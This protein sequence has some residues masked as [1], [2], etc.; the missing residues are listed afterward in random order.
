VSEFDDLVREH[1][2]SLSDDELRRLGADV[3]VDISFGEGEAAHPEPSP[4]PG[5]PGE[6]ERQGVEGVSLPR[7]VS[8]RSLV[9][10]P[11]DLDAGDFEPSLSGMLYKGFRI[12]PE[13]EWPAEAHRY[14]EEGVAG[15]ANQKRR[16]YVESATGDI[17][18]VPWEGS[19]VVWPW[20]SGWDQDMYRPEVT[21][22]L[23]EDKEKK[24]QR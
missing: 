15:H 24:K 4:P 1:L 5:D 9:E 10:N 19:Q 18:L 14:P 6:D 20:E 17:G 11:D 12:I 21:S 22:L 23:K 16:F 3:G 2:A 7:L 8:A 13:H